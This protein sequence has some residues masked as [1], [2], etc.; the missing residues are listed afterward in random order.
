MQ[1]S[2]PSQIKQNFLKEYKMQLNSAHK[3]EI[4]QTSCKLNKLEAY[5][6]YTIQ[7][8]NPGIKE[9]LTWS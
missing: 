7:K 3:I 6:K 4:V 5:L 9:I 1:R 2:L 8:Y